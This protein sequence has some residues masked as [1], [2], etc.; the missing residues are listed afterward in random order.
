MRYPRAA[1]R[2]LQCRPGH[3]WLS[4]ALSSDLLPSELETLVVVGSR[5]ETC[6]LYLG[7]QF[8]KM[9]D[10][11]SS[12]RRSRSGCE[13]TRCF[14]R[15]AS[16]ASRCH[17]CTC[18]KWR[19]GAVPVALPAQGESP[20]EADRA[21]T[22]RAARELVCVPKAWTAVPRAPPN[23]VARTRC[24]PARRQSWA[25]MFFAANK[26]LITIWG[27]TYCE[28]IQHTTAPRPP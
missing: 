13:G 8:L 21:N 10:K 16:R 7:T 22:P 28:V 5:S 19:L 15:L 12:L 25:Q 9:K 23:P 27:H 14:Q 26:D 11:N 24:S 20:A 2:P 18:R 17:T 4:L 6:L 3:C 1:G